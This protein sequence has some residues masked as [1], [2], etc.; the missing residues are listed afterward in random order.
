MDL[1]RCSDE[2]ADHLA[3]HHITVTELEEVW[4]EHPRYEVDGRADTTL[5]YGRTVAGRYLLVVTA[6]DAHGAFVITA[7]DMTNAERR[8]YQRKVGEA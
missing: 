1:P 7:R 4:T 2:R 3:L 8:T 6:E 5:V